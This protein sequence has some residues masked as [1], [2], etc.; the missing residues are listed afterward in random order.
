MRVVGVDGGDSDAAVLA[1]AV[2]LVPVAVII[3]AVVVVGS[4]GGI[5]GGT[6]GGI[7]GGGGSMR[8]RADC[9]DRC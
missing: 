9:A 4:T 3:D 2:D 7:T 5:T 1:V 6:D 8:E